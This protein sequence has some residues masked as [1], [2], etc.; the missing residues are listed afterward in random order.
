LYAWSW[1]YWAI[2]KVSLLVSS[3]RYSFRD[4]L[5]RYFLYGSGQATRRERERE[6]ELSGIAM[7]LLLLLSIMSVYQETD[8]VLRCNQASAAAA[9]VAVAVMHGM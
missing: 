3:P 2:I 4:K 1:N 9:A 7:L 8:D 5:G 6:R